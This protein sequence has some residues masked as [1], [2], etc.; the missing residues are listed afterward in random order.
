VNNSFRFLATVLLACFIVN[1]SA[2]VK[3]PA[4][5][6]DNMVLQREMNLP[7]WGTA[8][9]QSTIE[10]EL[11]GIKAFAYTTEDGKWLAYLPPMKAGGPYKLVVSGDREISFSNVMIGDV[12]LASGQSNMNFALSGATNG[13]ND[14][15]KANY[16]DIRL[17]YVENELSVH[18]KTDVSG[19]PWKICDS[20]S[21]K[22]FSAVA[23]YFGL[24]IYKNQ[25]VPIGL[26]QDSWSGSSCEAWTS[27]DMLNTMP[28]M[29]QRI[30]NFYKRK[31]T[32]DSMMADVK[33][34]DKNWNLGANSFEG[35]KKMVHTTK[36]ADESWK[37]MN[38]PG[39][40]SESEIGSFD[41][42]IWF[43]KKIDLPSN[44]KG[45]ELQIKLGKVDLTGVLYFNGEKIGETSWNFDEYSTLTV[46]GNLV[47]S[48]QNLLAIRLF[49]SWGKGGILGPADSL[50]VKINMTNEKVK[51]SLAGEWKYNDKIEP[52]FA[53]FEDFKRVPGLIFNA[54]IAPIIPYG[55]KGVIWYQGEGN[56]GRAYQYR[57]LFPLM[58]QDWRTRWKQGYFPFLFVQLPGY[59]SEQYQNEYEWAELREAQLLTLSHPNTG[60]AV[61]I[62]LD[63][64]DN[65]HPLNKADVGKRLALSAMKIAYNKDIVFSGPVYKSMQTEGNGIRISFTNT[66]SGL[67]LKNSE[68]LKGFELAGEDRKFYTAQAK[69]EGNDVIVFAAEVSN[70][71]AVRYAWANAPVCNLFNKEGLPASPFR[72]DSWKGV[73]EDKIE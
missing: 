47:K 57:T 25:K 12:W 31:I 24:K 59:S 69:I 29:K 27:Q 37:S 18:P 66:G 52:A 16:P 35:L 41:G 8:K 49:D 61:T 50:F 17:F 48:G 33:T 63:E 5:F 65:L 67:I 11:A 21:V 36:Y 32:N 7:V 13:K 9:P 54:K 62:D 15:A 68:A 1:V 56:A 39:A 10:V 19:G 34:G 22:N 60:M 46:P 23:Y 30:S 3:M 4:I 40:I 6:S 72:T 2:Q 51:I 42:I 58:I 43:R 20:N 64:K 44:F 55:I 28:V 45:K 14:I 53:K 26:I 73:T 71:V 38:L 70:P